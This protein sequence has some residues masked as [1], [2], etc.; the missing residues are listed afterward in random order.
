MKDFGVARTLNDAADQIARLAATRP[1]DTA[2]REALEEVTNACSDMIRLADM[3]LEESLTEPEEDGN[4]AAYNRA[5]A[6]VLTARA[7]LSSSPPADAEK[8]P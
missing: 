3:G 2:L 7:A 1:D 4:F 6:A 8:Q 5:K